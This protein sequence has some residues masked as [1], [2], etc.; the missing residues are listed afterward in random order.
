MN[1]KDTIERARAA[2]KALRDSQA[3]ISERERDCA[4]AAGNQ[5]TQCPGS[6]DQRLAAYRDAFALLKRGEDPT[7][8]RHIRDQERIF[9]C[10]Q[11]QQDEALKLLD[12]SLEHAANG[13]ARC[14]AWLGMIPSVTPRLLG[15]SAI[16]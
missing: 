8:T 4:P 5:R 14:V 3:I 9:I 16:I 2:E 12:R 13:A 10:N 15:K 11:G 6:E 7:I 1:S